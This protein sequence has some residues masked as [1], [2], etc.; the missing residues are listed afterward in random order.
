[1]HSTS[2]D[3]SA[4][5]FGNLCVHNVRLFELFRRRSFEMDDR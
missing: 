3:I 1:M 5:D 4:T 2:A